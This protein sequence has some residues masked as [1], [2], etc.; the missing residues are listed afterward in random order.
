[1]VI[2][3]DEALESETGINTTQKAYICATFTL[4]WLAHGNFFI[5]HASRKYSYPTPL[6]NFLSVASCFCKN[7]MGFLQM[8]KYKSLSR[9]LPILYLD[10]NL[11]I[12]KETSYRFYCQ[13]KAFP[14]FPYVHNKYLFLLQR[15]FHNLTH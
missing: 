5:L 13:A 7:I 6:V 8:C 1:M 10:Q 3:T 4:T 9:K 11:F 15:S 12:S 2:S 14:F